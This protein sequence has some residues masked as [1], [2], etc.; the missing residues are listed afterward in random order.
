MSPIKAGSSEREVITVTNNS[1]DG[2]GSLRWALR[3]TQ[4]KEG[5][6]DIVFA[7]P[8]LA[9]DL[10]EKRFDIGYWEISLSSPLPNLYRSDIR[11]NPNSQMPVHLISAGFQGP[12]PETKGEPK[13]LSGTNQ[14]SSMLIVGDIHHL[15]YP[16]EA[17]ES[18]PEISLNRINFIGN[19]ARGGNG[20]LSA[21]GGGASGGAI[22]LIDGELT[23]EDSVLQTLAANGGTGGRATTQGKTI[24]RNHK[25]GST[26]WKKVRSQF[27]GGTKGTRADLNYKEG[28][29]IWPESYGEDGGT[30]GLFN[31][32]LKRENN[33]DLSYTDPPAGGIKG[34]PGDCRYYY[35]LQNHSGTEHHAGD[36]GHGVSVNSHQY[37]FGG[38]GGGGASGGGVICQHSPFDS[39]RWGNGGNRGNGGQGHALGGNGGAALVINFGRYG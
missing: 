28:P 20:G 17:S 6:Y 27:G 18:S 3:Q 2:E 23:I 19:R 39:T 14:S 4:E 9:Q 25:D 10:E 22:T 16:D 29:Y 33:G 31:L 8:S 11:I 13:Q 1:N 21:G 24:N 12:P 35:Y 38:G 7:S 32:P 5:H 30:G 36:A 34:I 15:G 37:G 26:C